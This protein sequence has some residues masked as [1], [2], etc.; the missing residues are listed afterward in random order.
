MFKATI[1]DFN[2]YA[3]YFG[4]EMRSIGGKRAKFGINIIIRQQKK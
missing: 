4:E 3:Q 2:H 1:V